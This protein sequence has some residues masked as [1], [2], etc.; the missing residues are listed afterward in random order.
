MKRN[1][2]FGQETAG[3]ISSGFDRSIFLG[4]TGRALREV[5]GLGDR[6][7][8]VYP[9]RVD[10][11]EQARELLQSLGVWSEGVDIMALK[12]QH[13]AVKVGPLSPQAAQ[14]LKQ[15][16]LSKGGEAAIHGDV[17]LGRLNTEALLLGTVAQFQALLSKLKRQPF[18]LSQLS[19]DLERAVNN[20]V[21]GEVHRVLQCGGKSLRLGNRTLVMGVLNVTPDSFSDG[22]K[23]L[24]PDLAIERALEIESQ[25]ADILDLGGES[26]RPGA[27]K[28]SG[29]EELA[30]LLPVLEG[31]AR[32]IKIPI[33]VD[34]F[35]ASTAQA[36]LESGASIINDV[37][38]FGDPEMIDVLAKF[39]VPVILM[40]SLLEPVD[41]VLGD[42]VNVLREKK[43]EAIEGGIKEENIILDPGI[44][45]GDELFAKGSRENLD[46]I[47]HLDSLKALGS[48]ILVGTSRKSFISD[49][50]KVPPQERFEGTCATVAAA[51]MR[52]ADIVRVHDVKEMV[53]VARMTDAILG[54]GNRKDG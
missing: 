45:A 18:R 48:P 8:N 53:R 25:G 22:G 3:N 15:E 12:S 16:M 39:G 2:D 24:D 37:S 14:I 42:I 30:R 54:K 47:N 7:F 11:Q 38:G 33:S 49:V 23:Y 26:T 27:E 1:K 29:D 4:E 35:K 10:T 51:I 20:L 34:T 46:T 5:D 9:I 44:G 41:D 36:V 13:F 17:F 31:I 32:E 28:I 43:Q 6:D 52:G 40:H 21:S 50:L 19:E